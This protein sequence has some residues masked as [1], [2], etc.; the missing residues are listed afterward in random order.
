MLAI[1]FQNIQ[2]RLR[3]VDVWGIF[4]FLL[5]IGDFC[6]GLVLFSF[7][8][9]DVWRGYRCDWWWVKV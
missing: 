8:V 3:N 7:G 1:D 2:P 4:L 9:F 5:T 6:D